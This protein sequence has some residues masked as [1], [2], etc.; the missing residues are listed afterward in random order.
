MFEHSDLRLNRAVLLHI[1]ECQ[2]LFLRQMRVKVRN[3]RHRGAP[4]DLLICL[5]APD[6]CYQL[7]Q[8]ELLLPVDKHVITIMR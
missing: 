6:V 5:E 8:N 1:T 3:K 7:V 4:V 2:V